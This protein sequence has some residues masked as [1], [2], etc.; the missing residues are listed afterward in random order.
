MTCFAGQGDFEDA[1]IEKFHRKLIT[2]AEDYLSAPVKGDIAFL[3][4]SKG[5]HLTAFDVLPE[6]GIDTIVYNVF[7]YE[8]LFYCQD[9]PADGIF[10]DMKKGNTIPGD[11]TKN[12]IAPLLFQGALDH[13]IAGIG[14]K[15]WDQFK[16]YEK[17]VRNPEKYIGIMDFLR[18]RTDT[19]FP[20]SLCFAG[21]YVSMIKLMP[22]DAPS[23]CVEIMVNEIDLALVEH[24]RVYAI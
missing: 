23:V 16:E 10:E 22:T 1:D 24:L 12:M 15:F 2:T 4:D 11:V 8:S 17:S 18:N 13:E 20:D 14:L 6:L 9:Y 3:M 5:K 19:D 7:L 21:G